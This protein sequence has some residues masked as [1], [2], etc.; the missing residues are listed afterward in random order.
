MLLVFGNDAASWYSLL[1]TQLQSNEA[2]QSFILRPKSDWLSHTR[3]CFNPHKKYSHVMLNERIGN[4]RCQYYSI[5]F[6]KITMAQ[7]KFFLET[8]IINLWTIDSMRLIHRLRAWISLNKGLIFRPSIRRRKAASLP[9]FGSMHD[10][11]IASWF[12]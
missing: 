7:E 12:I 4:G 5:Q 8:I 2:W 6:I 11:C 9:F 1:F 3:Q 10:V